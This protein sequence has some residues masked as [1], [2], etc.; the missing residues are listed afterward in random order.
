[1]R[2]PV[3]EVLLCA[4]T[5][6]L[7]RLKKLHNWVALNSVLLPPFLTKVVIL[8]VQA[9]SKELIKTLVANTIEN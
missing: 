7:A 8:D 5:C 3:M 2:I 1:M 4:A 6:S 9:S